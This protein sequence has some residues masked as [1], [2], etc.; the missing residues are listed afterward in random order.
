MKVY[1]AIALVIGIVPVVVCAYGSAFL[2]VAWCV[3]LSKIKS[4]D[5]N[6]D[7]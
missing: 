3:F 2:S 1:I 6:A 7:V 4:L 5:K